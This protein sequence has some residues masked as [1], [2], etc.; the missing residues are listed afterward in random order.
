MFE[1]EKALCTQARRSSKPLQNIGIHV[2]VIVRWVDKGDVNRGVEGS[3][4][5][6]EIH[7]HDSESF[8][9]FERRQVLSN[10][11]A[12]LS[13]LINEVDQLRPTADRL[14]SDR[15]DSR[16]AIKEN[17]RVNAIAEYVE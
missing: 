10:D 3:Q 15:T 9:D 2:V 14:D 4:S 7:F 12:S 6:H 16:A 13:G 5:S 17:R 8:Q 11:L 1:Y